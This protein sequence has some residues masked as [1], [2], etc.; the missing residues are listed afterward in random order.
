MTT[1]CKWEG[2][3]GAI[4][5]GLTYSTLSDDGW[6]HAQTIVKAKTGSLPPPEFRMALDNALKSAAGMA[7]LQKE[8][9]PHAIR[10]NLRRALAAA[11]RLGHRLDELDGNSRQVLG[12]MSDGDITRFYG[13][14]R[15]LVE[16][17]RLAVDKAK[18]LPAT[19]EGQKDFTALSMGNQLAL[20]MKDHLHKKPTTTPS[21]MFAQLYAVLA[22][23]VG[24][25]SDSKA[26]R[27]AIRFHKKSCR[28]DA[29][30]VLGSAQGRYSTNFSFD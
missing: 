17:L 3:S 11:I 13:E 12:E 15:S 5:S 7:H 23:V 30:P 24:V 29:A 10:R 16:A 19:R 22:E 2:P 26:V 28:S 8:G 21:G 20:E 9:G 1:E 18:G 6:E 4:L 27:A 14:V 25:S